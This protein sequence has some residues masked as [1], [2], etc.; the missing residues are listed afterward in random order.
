MKQISF[1]IKIGYLGFFI[2]MLLIF[3]S[4]HTFGQEAIN[5][6][7]GA[8]VLG[9]YPE[10]YGNYD[11]QVV[12][13]SEFLMDKY[14]VTN[15]DFAKF[16][17]DSG[18]QK[19]QNWIVEGVDDSLAGWVWVRK[20]KIVCPKYWNLD[21]SPFWKNDPYS[22]HE[23]TPVVGVSWFEAYAYAKWKGKR[24]PTSA[25]WEKA[26]RGTSSHYGELEGTGVGLIYPWG[27]DFFHAQNPPEYQ[28]CNWRLRY[29]A[30]KFP[31]T[32]GRS[33]KYGYAR[34]TWKTDGFRE[35]TSPVGFYSPHGD[36]P[37]GIADMAG[38]VWEWT[39]S[40]YPAYEGIMKIMRGGGWYESTPEHLKN[41][42][43][44]GNGP[45]Y[46]GRS[47]GFRCAE[48]LNQSKK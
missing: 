13:V 17:E 7:E 38:N 48:N 37:Y 14:E 22:H 2:F 23:N 27:N 5:I 15:K 42:Y 11:H 26:A 43:I 20:S 47:L 16:I 10:G 24:L 28:L 18:Y 40:D 12:T 8:V 6:S 39:D 41:G 29:Y 25:E 33:K 36:S 21:S 34:E 46:R 1:I 19:K 44:H 31:D 30:Y 32:D 4:I 45:Y 3:K 9:N 35:N